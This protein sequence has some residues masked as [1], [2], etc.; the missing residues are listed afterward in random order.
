LSAKL[1][2]TFADR[3]V[4][5]GQ[6]GGSPRAV[7]SVLLDTP[8]G[9]SYSVSYSFSFALPHIKLRPSVRLQSLFLL[10][11]VRLNLMLPLVRVS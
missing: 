9:L 2:P 4:S 6:C 3:R 11:L 7:I 5:H 10:L 8:G 1:V